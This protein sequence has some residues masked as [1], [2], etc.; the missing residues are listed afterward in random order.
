MSRPSTHRK[1]PQKAWVVLDREWRLHGADYRLP[2]FW[3][4]KSAR[5]F[6]LFSN[7]DQ[8]A[9]QEVVIDYV[10]APKESIH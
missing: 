8:G 3:T 2:V 6:A 4:K 10:N 9:V 5:Q 7:L 1:L